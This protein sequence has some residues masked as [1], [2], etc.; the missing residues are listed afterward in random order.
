[1]CIFSDKVISVNTTRIFAR[2]TEKAEQFLV[3]S[4]RMQSHNDVAMILPIPIK[5]RSGEKAVKFINLKE[6]STFFTDMERGFPQPLKKKSLG[7]R[8]R[9]AGAVTDSKLK[10][11]KVGSFEASFVPTRRDFGRLDKRFRLPDAT[12]DLLPKY[13]NYGFVVFKFRKGA[14]RPHPMAFRFPRADPRRLYFPTVH[15]HD[16]KVHP[17]EKF[18]HVLYAQFPEDDMRLLHGWTESPSPA[19]GF[20]KIAKTSKVV[21][22]DL[23]C[24]RRQMK[25]VYKNIDVIV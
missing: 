19:D 4:M 2:A 17:R 6:Y 1:M 12:W 8:S 15:I 20:M 14:N 13:K 3:Y 21:K 9:A 5:P 25:G 16:G 11:V 7:S 24:Y 10:V 23:H 22:S 18:D